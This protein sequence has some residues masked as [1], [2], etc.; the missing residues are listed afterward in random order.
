VVDRLRQTGYD[1]VEVQFGSKPDDPRKYANKRAEMWG[2]MKEWLTVGCLGRDE[3][4]ATD[5][6]SVEY[7]FRV[8]DT[9]LLE[10]KESMKKRSLA[11]PDDADAL[12]LT[13]AF[14]V[15]E[16]VEPEVK[17]STGRQ[18]YDPYASLNRR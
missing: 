2:R 13:F 12:A 8:D 3:A 14:P 1:V 17:R 10:S 9:I 11:S 18:P 6:T 15:Q 16:F 7:S 5:L 4:L